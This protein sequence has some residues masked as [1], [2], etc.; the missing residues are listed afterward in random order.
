MNF[1][2]FKWNSPIKNLTSCVNY[3]PQ[4]L[5]LK[6]KKIKPPGNAWMRHNN[7]L[8]ILVHNINLSL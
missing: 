5:Y 3:N 1:F 6:N 8:W 2:F 4:N 7:A